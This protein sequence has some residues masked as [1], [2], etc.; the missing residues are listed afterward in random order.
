MK[1]NKKKVRNERMATLSLMLCLFFN[2]LGYDAIFKA[3]LDLTGSY[4]HTVLVFYLIA[5]S[6]LGFYFYFSRI[7][8][9]NAIYKWGVEFIGKAKRLFV[10]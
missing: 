10:R 7:N 6:F 3:I 2:P 9:L 1:T 8:P 5:G 4:W